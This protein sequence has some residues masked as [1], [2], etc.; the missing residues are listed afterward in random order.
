M[1]LT[2]LLCII[3]MAIMSIIMIKNGWSIF[4]Y[5]ISL[6]T[7]SGIINYID[8]VD[9]NKKPSAKGNK[10]QRAEYFKS[11]SQEEQEEFLIQAEIKFQESLKE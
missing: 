6:I 9:I 7:L 3:A 4:G 10:R 11:L 5:F 1:K 8:I 2:K